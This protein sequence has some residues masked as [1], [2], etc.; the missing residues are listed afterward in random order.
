MV[1]LEQSFHITLIGH[2]CIIGQIKVQQ[3]GANE[4]VLRHSEDDEENANKFHE[5][6]AFS[7][8]IGFKAHVS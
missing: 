4:S 8:F 5:S 7:F 3:S 6:Y 1:E 2:A